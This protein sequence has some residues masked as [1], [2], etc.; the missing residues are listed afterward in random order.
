MATDMRSAI[1]ATLV[2]VTMALVLAACGQVTDEGQLPGDSSPT[3]T[4]A[5]VTTASTLAAPRNVATTV[6]P[7]TTA[8][9]PCVSIT[10]E[11]L[12]L[13]RDYARDVRGIAGADEAA[14]KARARA[15]AEKARRLGC[16]V[17]PGIANWPS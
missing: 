14:Y 2:V 3:S 5:P 8:G 6:Q 9:P 1:R 4:S 15:L 7:T 11:S 12:A 13:Q 10:V 17:P 16:P